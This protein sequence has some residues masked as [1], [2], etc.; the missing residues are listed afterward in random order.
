MTAVLGLVALR[1]ITEREG[2]FYSNNY[3]DKVQISHLFPNSLPEL[4]GP[5]R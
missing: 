3:L 2:T 5:G 4:V 1:V